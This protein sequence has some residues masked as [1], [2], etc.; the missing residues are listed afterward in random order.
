MGVLGEST[1]QKSE[2]LVVLIHGIKA[3]F[4]APSA[5]NKVIVLQEEKMNTPAQKRKDSEV[6]RSSDHL[7]WKQ[8]K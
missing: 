8:R 6:E 2:Y 4:Y 1:R 7:G 5:C 3:G